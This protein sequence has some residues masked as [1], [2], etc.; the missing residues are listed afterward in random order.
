MHIYIVYQSSER[1]GDNM[2]DLYMN[3]Y[4][5]TAFIERPNE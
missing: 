3:G 1:H 4:R 5:Y 2:E